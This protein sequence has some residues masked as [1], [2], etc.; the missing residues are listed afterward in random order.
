MPTSGRSLYLTLDAGLQKVM[1]DAYGEEAGAAVVLDLR[2]G[3]IL[4]MYSSPSYDPNLFLNRL[5][6]EMV[7]RYLNN[8]TRPMLNRAI[9]GIYAPGSTFKL[10]VALAGLEKGVI[11]PQTVI[12]CAGKKNFYGRDFRCDKPTGHGGLSLVQAIAQSCD[13]YFYEVGLAPGHRRSL[14]HGGEV[15]LHGPHRRGPAPG[16]AHPH[17]QP[18]LEAQG[19]TPGSQVVRGRDHQRGH[20]PGGRGRHA[21]RPG[22]LLRHCWPPRGR[23]SLPTSSTASATTR[24]TSWNS[25]QR[26][27]S[28]GH[29]PGSP[30]LGGPG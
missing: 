22:A 17:P 5:S 28:P 8:P 30:D 13:V 21:H 25:R 12:Y 9:Q 15:R 3:G 26:A 1:Q 14:R 19:L 23:C 16:E 4:A 18:G 24:A 29:A 6:Q 11:T 2:D 27:A 10:L 7:D 20:R